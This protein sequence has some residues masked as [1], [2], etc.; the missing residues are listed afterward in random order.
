VPGPGE[1]LVW[2]IEGNAA[3]LFSYNII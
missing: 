2:K 1:R 3:M